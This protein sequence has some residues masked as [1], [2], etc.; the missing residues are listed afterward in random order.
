MHSQP[1][2]GCGK[3]QLQTNSDIG[4]LF[5]DYMKSK[6]GCVVILTDYVLNIQFKV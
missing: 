4:K 5:G 3:R 1:V 6:Y 2:G